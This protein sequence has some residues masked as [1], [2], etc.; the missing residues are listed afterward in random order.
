MSAASLPA[1]IP[2]IRFALVGAGVIGRV[3]AEALAASPDAELVAVHDIDPGVAAELG[4]RFGVAVEADLDALLARTDVDAVTVC[5][6]SG[7]HAEVAVRVLEAGRHLLVEKPLEV[8]LDA[9]RRIAAAAAAAPAGTVAS[10]ISQHRFDPASVAVHRAA[11]AGDFGRV[12]SATATVPWWRAPGYYAS[13]GWR[14]TLALDGGGALVNQGIHTLDLLLW[15]LGEPVDVVA[16]TGTLAHE[17][18]EVEDVVAAVLTFRSGALATLHATTAA[19][20]GLTVRVAVL[21]D[22]GSAVIDNDRLDYLHSARAAGLS[23]DGVSSG[24]RGV[25]G[26]A[27]QAVDLVGPEESG[28][29][30]GG[31]PGTSSMV[32]GHGR[33]YAD[34][35]D[36]I[37]TGREP[38]VTIAD[39]LRALATVLAVYRSAALGRAV[40]LDESATTPDPAPDTDTEPDTDTVPA[41]AGVSA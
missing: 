1:A 25:G 24:L 21:G 29:H 11:T 27:D 14:G 28:R 17:G 10:V 37:R 39:G 38:G 40:R 20:P 3:H 7:R 8:S 31:G 19:Y 36:A 5:T 2:T 32:V 4:T 33:Q 23:A 41:A 30:R 26:A 34:V 9:A 22:G 6:P 18:I 12:C 15:L 13:A 16:R 35:V